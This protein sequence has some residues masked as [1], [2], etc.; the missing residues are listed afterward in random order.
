MARILNSYDLSIDKIADLYLEGRTYDIRG[1]SDGTFAS[2]PTRALDGT[3]TVGEGQIPA[4][5]Q[6][7]VQSI[8]L[9]ATNKCKITAYAPVPQSSPHPASYLDYENQE[10]RAVFGS[11]GG[12]WVSNPNLFVPELSTVR[13]ITTW[14]ETEGFSAVSFQGLLLPNDWHY[15]GNIIEVRSDSVHWS[16]MGNDA[17]GYPYLGVNFTANRLANRLREDGIK[18]RV[19][20]KGFGG[21]KSGDSIYA[22]G[23]GFYPT[24][25]PVWCYIISYGLN[26]CSSSIP[27]NTFKANLI[28]HIKD[29]NRN[30]PNASIILLAPT[31]TDTAS[32]ATIQDYRDAVYDVA[33]DATYGG[34]NR[35]VYYYD[36]STAF[37][38]GG[39][40]ATDINFRTGERSAGNRLHP[41]GEGH[42]LIYQGL[43]TVFQTTHAYQNA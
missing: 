5:F 17:A 26:D 23:K 8:G 28:E 37:S 38:L 31:V 43:Y 18:C 22:L 16:N 7:F 41:S 27:I 33:I 19:R 3:Q 39:D 30:N 15:E 21:S 11:G 2:P 25:K 35:K 10:F 9:S 1:F 42:D 32:R 14:G 12:Q 13:G 29:R 4:G 24:H 6:F 20:L 36:Q 40:P 34:T